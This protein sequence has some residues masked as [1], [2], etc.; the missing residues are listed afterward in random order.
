MFTLRKELLKQTA[1]SHTQQCSELILVMHSEIT[2]GDSVDHKGVPRMEI[3][4]DH[5][6]GKG[7]TCS[8]LFL[9]LTRHVIEYEAQFK[10]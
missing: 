4:V 10:E 5:E 8:S 2:P 3:K 7:P 6:Q 9:A 1:F